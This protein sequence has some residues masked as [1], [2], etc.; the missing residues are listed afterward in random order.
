VSGRELGLEERKE[1]MRIWEE[2]GDAGIDVIGE[3][4]VHMRGCACIVCVH[5]R[6]GRVGY[7]G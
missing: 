1:M 2:E 5:G 7:I 4:Y 6:E 3:M